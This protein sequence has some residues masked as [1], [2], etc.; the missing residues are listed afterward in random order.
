MPTSAMCRGNEWG[1][2]LLELV[3]V[4]ALIGT[5]GALVMP[6]L[7]RM[8]ESWQREV[9]LQNIAEQLCA[10]GYR[11]RLD[12]RETMIDS[13]GVTPS[14]SLQLPAG[15]RLSAPQR[16]VYYSNGNCSGGVVIVQQG[17]ILRR[18]NLSPPLCQ[19]ESL[20]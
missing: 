9:Q 7:I 19:P 16:L 11:A 8:Q 10:L 1:F 12:G 4:L 5:M 2:T 14:G 18:L 15:W 17:Q 13:S 3:V 6:N 20:E